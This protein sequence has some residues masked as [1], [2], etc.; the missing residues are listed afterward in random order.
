MYLMLLC[1]LEHHLNLTGS[2]SGNT[3]DKQPLQ[4]L[5]VSDSL[6]ASKRRA[7]CTKGRNIQPLCHHLQQLIQI[8]SRNYIG[9]KLHK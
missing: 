5:L 1:P 2:Y 6:T 9:T 7:V 3:I 4:Q 8:T